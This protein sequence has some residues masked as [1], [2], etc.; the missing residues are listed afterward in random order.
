MSAW[1][2]WYHAI[3]STYGSWLP[4]DPRG[5]RT[6]KHR[7]HVHGDYKSPPLP[8]RYEIRHADARRKL[9]RPS[10]VLTAPQRRIV[11]EEFRET[12]IAHDG[13]IIVIAVAAT[14]LHVLAQFLPRP[15]KPTFIERGLQTS[16]MDDPVRYLM[17]I[18]KQWSAKRLVREGHFDQGPI[19]A[20]RGK[21]VPLRD[22]QHQLNV[23]NYIMKHADERAAV[24]SFRDAP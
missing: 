4:G 14:H 24:W 19:W 16:A 10:V 23:F 18:A 7:E 9:K 3:T 22:R 20:K 5:F 21:I 6:R 11:L 8:G 15:P 12:L 13:R 17:G 2:H 1:R